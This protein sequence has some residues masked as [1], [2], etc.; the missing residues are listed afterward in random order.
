MTIYSFENTVLKKID[1][2]TFSE[3]GILERQHLQRAL[4]EQIDIISPQSLVIAEEF[5]EWS[6]SNRRI[7]LLAIDKEARLVVIES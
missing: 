3:E 4:R 7:D 6:N 1:R 2:T 5:S